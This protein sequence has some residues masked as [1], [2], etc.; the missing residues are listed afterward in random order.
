MGT[1]DHEW[2]RWPKYRPELLAH[3]N[4]LAVAAATP[5]GVKKLVEHRQP[6]FAT[7]R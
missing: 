7:R 3:V 2:A 5:H 4:K 6:V 1:K